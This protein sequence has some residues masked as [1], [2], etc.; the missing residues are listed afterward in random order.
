LSGYKCPFAYELEPEDIEKGAVWLNLK[1]K[2]I[3]TAA[4]Q[5]P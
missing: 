2:N 4:S 3:G 5:K 1:L